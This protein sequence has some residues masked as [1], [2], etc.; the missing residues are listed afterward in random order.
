MKHLALAASAAFALSANI[1][2]AQAPAPAASDPGNMT[3][4]SRAI[5]ARY[6][7][8]KR[9]IVVSNPVTDGTINSPSINAESGFVL[10]RVGDNVTLGGLDPSNFPDANLST[11]TNALT[12]AQRIAQ[13]TRVVAGQWIDIYG[14]YDAFSVGGQLDNGYGTVMHLQCNRDSH[15]PNPARFNLFATESGE[16]T[17]VNRR[18][19]WVDQRKA[20]S[21]NSNG[22]ARLLSTKTATDGPSWIPASK[23]ASPAASASL[24][25]LSR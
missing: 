23:A 21:W 20:C 16:A 8:V 5:K 18:S 10:L 25:T 12:D 13:N 2:W 11:A 1:V 15:R 9:D 4:F 24:R 17:R 22:C 7:N 19:G 3:R 6:D 14:D